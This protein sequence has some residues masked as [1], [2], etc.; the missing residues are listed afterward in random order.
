[1]SPSPEPQRP[2]RD[3]PTAADAELWEVKQRSVMVG[4]LRTALGS[5]A[6]V[7]GGLTRGRTNPP[8]FDPPA[9]D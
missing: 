8:T 4:A 1:M 6:I 7:P 3:L 9:R 2:P 5:L